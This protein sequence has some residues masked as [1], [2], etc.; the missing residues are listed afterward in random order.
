MTPELTYLVY[1][2]LW[3]IITLLVQVLTA[4]L[5]VGLP[6][7]VGN[8]EGLVLTGMAF[9]LERAANNSLL[10]LALI[11]PAVITLH[12]TKQSPE[13]AAQTMLVFL[14]ARIGY[15]VLYALGIAWFR[16]LAWLT[17][18]A[19]TALLYVRALGL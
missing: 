4:M 14:L 12:L 11:A 7:L 2:G 10:A 5:Q 1:F 9:R 17:G 6:A 8:R 16:T 18:F 15:V 13:L 19:C 3:V